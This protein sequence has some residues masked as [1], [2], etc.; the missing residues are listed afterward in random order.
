[1]RS[2]KKKSLE[3][4]LIAMRCNTIRTGYVLKKFCI[5]F[6]KYFGEIK[7]ATIFASQF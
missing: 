3:K 1:M 7:K 5:F 2:K 4:N 6:E